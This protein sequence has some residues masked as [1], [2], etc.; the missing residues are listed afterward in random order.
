MRKILL[1]SLILLFTLSSSPARA[2]SLS[3]PFTSQSPF[4]HWVEPYENFCEEASVVMTAHFIWG[5]S[6]SREIADFEMNIIKQ[7]EEIVLGDYKDTSMND[8][9]NILKNLYGFKNIVVK[10][11]SNTS[12]IKNELLRGNVVIVP[13]AGRMLGN[14]Y[15]VPPGPLYHVLLI[16]GFD[17]TTG[18]FIA[19]DPGTQHGNGYHYN[20]YVLFNAIHD[21]NKGDVMKGRK[22][23]IVAGR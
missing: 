17:D 16:K 14:P 6:L 9:A 7:Y 15:F 8:T 22:M 2:F 4:G 18:D 20:Q 3:V 5:F 13:V 10:E 23:M 19:N 1:P 21:W 12:V 11:V